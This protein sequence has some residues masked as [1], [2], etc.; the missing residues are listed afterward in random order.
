MTSI[1]FIPSNDD[2]VEESGEFRLNANACLD[3]LRKQVDL[4]AVPLDVLLLKWTEEAKEGS[5][6]PDEFGERARFMVAEL[7]DGESAV[8]VFCRKCGEGFQRGS[9]TRRRWND[10]YECHGICIGT[11]GYQIDCPND[12]CLIIIRERIY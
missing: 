2:S 4:Y 10:S 1:R 9:L 11:S 12:H 5:G 3:Y 8:Q 7:V 6:I